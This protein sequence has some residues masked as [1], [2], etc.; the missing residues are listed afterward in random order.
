MSTASI[1]I[2]PLKKPIHPINFADLMKKRIKSLNPGIYCGG[3]IRDGFLQFGLAYNHCIFLNSKGESTIVVIPAATGSGKSESAKVYLSGIVKM[4]MSGLL[5][6]S[7]VAVAIEAA[8]EINIIAGGKVAGAYY[9]ISEKNPKND[10]LWHPINRLPRIAIIT[11]AMFVQR[12]DSG[13]EVD[14]L[15]SFH[16]RQRDIMIIDERIDLA[17]RISFDTGEIVDAVAILKRD[18]ALKKLAE[19]LSNFNNIIFTVKK[20]GTFEYK[21]DFK[22]AHVALRKDLL[23]FSVKLQNGQFNLLPRLR[24]RLRN[25]DPDRANVIGLLDR[26]AYV[27]NDRFKHTVEGKKVVCHRED[28]LSGKFGSVVV[29][30]ATSTINPEY[31]FKVR[32]NHNIIPITKIESR[33]YSNV[34]LNVCSLKGANQSRS[35]IYKDPK[36]ENTP[37]EIIQ[38]YLKVIGPILK[39]GD[40][41]LVVTYKAA[42]P[43]FRELNPYKNQVKFIHWGGK[44]ARGSY[45]FKDFNKA[46]IIGWHRRPLHYYVASVGAI[47]EFEHYVPSNGSMWSDAT[48]LQNMLIVDDMIQ[49]FNRVRC[50]TAIDKYGNCPPVELY[51][52][53]GGDKKM[54]KVIK[55]SIA[56]EM[57]DI[58]IRDWKPK[59]LK[60][61]MQKISKDEERAKIFILWLQVKKGKYDEISL[62]ELKQEFSHLS[63]YSVSVAI[64]SDIFKNLLKKEGINMINGT[65]K[66]SPKRFIF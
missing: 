55:I 8:E 1:P 5:V 26:I 39:S 63:E 62:R 49:F 41:L 30:D 31:D 46:M 13:K 64:N 51:L 15:R 14:T 23:S 21:G 24:G 58:V 53:T 45:K 4:G 34:I 25:T 11:H 52:L 7:E 47:N 65:G 3:K 44:D 22:Q 66:G 16:G 32:N 6:V 20:N 19:I 61:I 35:A 37:K 40:K 48:H 33:N 2:H 9:C 17:K 59:E 36:K 54:E 38:A 12:S 10:E 27:I 50:R 18:S 56:K 42:V 29:L 28:D 43:K 57:P 60:T